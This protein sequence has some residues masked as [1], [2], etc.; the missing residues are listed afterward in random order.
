MAAARADASPSLRAPTRAAAREL[1]R[2]RALE[3]ARRLKEGPTALADAH[4]SV[5]DADRAQQA[6]ICERERG[7]EFEREFQESYKVL[8][9]LLAKRMVVQA[10]CD[11]AVAKLHYE[12]GLFPQ[13]PW[14]RAQLDVIAA[15][16]CDL[17]H[18]DAR[19]AA[20]QKM[21]FQLQDRQDFILRH[22]DLLKHDALN[23]AAAV[24]VMRWERAAERE[25]RRRDVVVQRGLDDFFALSRF[26]PPSRVKA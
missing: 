21:T 4:R 3:A 14:R 22:L 15:L 25:E 23:A 9:Q 10:S 24:D 11:D 26:G 8:S 7:A 19:I 20:Q 13:R 17:G 6:Y 2:A 18:W 16:R 1:Q 12:D 5:L